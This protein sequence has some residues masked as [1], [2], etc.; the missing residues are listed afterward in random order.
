[1]ASPTTEPPSKRPKLDGG[2]EEGVV[3]EDE[4][5]RMLKEE[6]DDEEEA[7]LRRLKRRQRWKQSAPN[8][9]NAADT[10]HELRREIKEEQVLKS[11]RLSVAKV[12]LE[13][14]S[15]EED[16]AASSTNKHHD[17]D[18]DF[19]M[20][21]SSVS[22][23]VNTKINNTTAN[24]KK[25]DFDDEQGYYKPVI[26][27]TIECPP[28]QFQ[29]LGVVGKG[30]LNYLLSY[31]SVPGSYSILSHFCVLGVFSTVLKGKDVST[32]KEVALKLI[33]NNETMAKAAL[34][35][36]RALRKLSAHANVV[37]LIHPTSIEAITEHHNHVV[38]C[39]DYQQYNLRDVLQK[40]GRGVGLSLES[41]QLYFPQLLSAL[42]HLKAHS[43]LHSDIKPD[44]ILVSGDFSTLQVCDF[45]SATMLDEGGM[46]PTPYLVSRFYRAPEIILGLV[47]SFPIDLWSATVT[48]VELFLGKVLFHG[49][50]NNEMLLT[51]MQVLGPFSPKQVKQHVLQ[52]KI[53]PGLPLQ[54]DGNYFLQQDVDKATGFLVKKRASLQD[55]PTRPLQ[56]MLLKA[57][58]VSDS[59]VLVMKFA[60]LLRGCLALDPTRRIDLRDAMHHDFFQVTTTT[61]SDDKIKSDNDCK[62]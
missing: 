61:K 10:P 2:E 62:N 30:M 55:F 31:T 29:V 14:A 47:P 9:D 46:I 27:E 26:G 36:V 6:N 17:D 59:R 21:S 41:I 35:E 28:S 15:V 50:S 13:D 1:M 37:P 45:G 12:E 39:F 51:M 5:L 19:D 42:R 40:F 11:E 54:F 34:T 25:D 7:R 38:L 33:R 20:F 3:N 22:P 24:M 56:S 44:N 49:K 48:I 58:S 23:V 8:E 16:A 57:K 32:N 53:H 4:L 43:I 60:N 52:C 18:D